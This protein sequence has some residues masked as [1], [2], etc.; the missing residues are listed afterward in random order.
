MLTMNKSKV[1]LSVIS[2]TMSV[3]CFS[4]EKPQ[5]VWKEKVHNF[6]QVS[7]KDSLVETIFFFNVKGEEPLLIHNV[8][9]SCGCTTVDWIKH[10]IKPG[11]KG[12]VKVL[13][14]PKGQNGYFDKR[15]IVESNAQK[16]LDLLR[17]KGYVK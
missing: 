10:P 5:I 11:G 8:S 3:L 6:N 17:I 2:L 9:V 13:F 7:S 14:S 15:F 12:Y 16:N 1:L 4:Q